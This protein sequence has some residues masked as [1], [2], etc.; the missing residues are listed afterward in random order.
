MGLSKYKFSAKS[1][2]AS[3]CVHACVHACSE[4][5]VVVGVRYIRDKGVPSQASKAVFKHPV[6]TEQ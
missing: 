3:V 1:H 4:W 6:L 5:T 2:A